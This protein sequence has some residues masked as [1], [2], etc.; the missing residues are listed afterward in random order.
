MHTRRP[1]AGEGES[2]TSRQI[3]G[4]LAAVASGGLGAYAMAAHPAPAWLVGVLAAVGVLTGIFP[5]STIGGG[6]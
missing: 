4:T 5:V 3:I 1:N 6:K 2:M